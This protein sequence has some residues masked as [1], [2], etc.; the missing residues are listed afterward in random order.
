MAADKAA[1]GARNAEKRGQRDLAI[2][3]WKIARKWR[4]KAIMLRALT[5][6]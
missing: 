6:A 1:E 2:D 5:D 4:V 3:L